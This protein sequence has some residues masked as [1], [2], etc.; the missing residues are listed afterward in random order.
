MNPC[1]RIAGQPDGVQHHGD[2]EDDEERVDQRVEP[3]R[4]RIVAALQRPAAS[5]IDGAGLEILPDVIR[6]SQAENFKEDRAEEGIHTASVLPS[7]TGSA[8][9]KKPLSQ[10]CHFAIL[11]R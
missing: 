8:A 7:L 4:A 5:G 10:N 2:C 6:R 9:A 11:L 3:E 1:E